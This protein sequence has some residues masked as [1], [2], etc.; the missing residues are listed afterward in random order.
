ME[1]EKMHSFFWKNQG[2]RRPERHP[3]VGR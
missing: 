3:C 2:T 1:M